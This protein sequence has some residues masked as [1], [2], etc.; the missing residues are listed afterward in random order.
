MSANRRLRHSFNLLQMSSTFK[1]FDTTDITSFI[2]N[3]SVGSVR[4][5]FVSFFLLF[6]IPTARNT[7]MR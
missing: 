4:T 1:F 7:I 2:N 5:M 3:Q 6:I